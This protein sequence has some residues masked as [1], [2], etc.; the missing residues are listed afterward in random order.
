MPRVFDNI[1]KSLL[2]ALAE[3]MAVSD[4]ADSCVGYE[5]DERREPRIICSLG[6]IA[7]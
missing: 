1:E 3:T 6:L 7:Q 5:E 2:P 4:R